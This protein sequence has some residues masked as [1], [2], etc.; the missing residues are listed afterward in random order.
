[1]K[2]T[3][4]NDAVR[5]AAEAAAS[6]AK[7]VLEAHGLLMDGVLVVAEVPGP[8][9]VGTTDTASWLNV[10]AKASLPVVVETLRRVIER[11]DAQ[12]ALPTPPKPSKPP[13]GLN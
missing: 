8:G 9:S 5:E 2:T 10:S 11:L 6:A 4:L 3:D 1:M 13:E 7:A 12:A